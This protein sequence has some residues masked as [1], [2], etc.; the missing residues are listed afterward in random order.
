MSSRGMESPSLWMPAALMA[1][2]SGTTQ[3]CLSLP[4]DGSKMM[5]QG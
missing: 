4:T 3:F 2:R 1:K 5:E